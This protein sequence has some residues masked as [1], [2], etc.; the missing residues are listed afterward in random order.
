M[1]TDVPA[2]VLGGGVNALSIVRSLGR[3]GVKV[4]AAAVDPTPLH[5]RYCALPFALAGASRTQQLEQLLLVRPREEFNGAVLLACDDESVAFVARHKERLQRHYLTEINP[6]QQQLAM[7]DKLTT[8]Q[9]AVEADVPVPRFYP[10]VSLQDLEAAAG[11]IDYPAILKPRDS[12]QF[13][14]LF[15][16]KY[17]PT[18]SREQCLQLGRM[19][20][21]RSVAF[22][23]CEMISGPDDRAG[24]LYAYLDAS[25]ELL[26]R[27]TKNCV[28]RLPVNS[29]MGTLQ[30]T[31]RL[32]EVEALGM[33]FFRHIDYVG[34]GN[35]E[36]KYDDRDGQLKLMECNPRFTAPQ[37]QLLRSGI[38]AAMLVYRHLTRQPVEKA[39]DFR[40]GVGFWSPLWDLRAFFDARRRYP[41][42]F[43]SYLRS[44]RNIEWVFPV[45][46]RD[47]LQPWV[48]AV[49][50]EL[51]QGSEGLARRIRQAGGAKPATAE[52]EVTVNKLAVNGNGSYSRIDHPSAWT[53]RELERDHSWVY[54]LT[55]LEAGELRAVGAK[56]PSA[57]EA[58]AFDRDSVPE[59]ALPRLAPRLG[60]ISAQLEQGRGIVLLK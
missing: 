41:Q 16:C 1:N 28:R 23:L 39:L 30:V 35:V 19:L 58:L 34:F 14:Q 8:L 36:F 17:L 27:F 13:N 51:R 37:E 46:D 12:W 25:G 57:P 56:L 15:G 49:G 3:A 44:L 54:R 9:L 52:A 4:A 7:L 5:S 33:R 60:E 11:A 59:L 22:I 6:P 45:F 10:V 38:D 55:A 42:N 48:S 18:A 29:G 43:A 31:E 24:S 53:R 50:R 26:L 47:D 40:E 21:Q 2:L 32:P 20:L